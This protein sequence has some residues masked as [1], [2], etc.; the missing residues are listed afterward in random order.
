VP[1]FALVEEGLFIA[2]EAGLYCLGLED[3]YP[4]LLHFYSCLKGQTSRAQRI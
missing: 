3:C 2:V 1:A 4:C